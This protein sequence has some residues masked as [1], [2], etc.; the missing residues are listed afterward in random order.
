MWGIMQ[1]NDP[2]TPSPQKKSKGE[3]KQSLQ[4][5]IKTTVYMQYPYKRIISQ[6]YAI[7][8]IIQKLNKT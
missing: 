3:H 6:I 8:L 2:I 7:A 4:R 1:L 5:T